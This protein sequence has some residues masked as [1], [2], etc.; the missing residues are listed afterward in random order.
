V[1][2]WQDGLF[3]YLYNSYRCDKFGL[4]DDE[5]YASITKFCTKDALKRHIMLLILRAYAYKLE[6]SDMCAK[7]YNYF[8][9]QIY[10]IIYHSC[11]IHNIK[12]Y[13]RG[14]KK[15]KPQLVEKRKSDPC[16]FDPYEQLSPKPCEDPLK[17][18]IHEKVREVI[19]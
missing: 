7:E 18:S 2:F 17:L 9:V 11:K 1:A 13:L 16:L 5:G 12:L 8:S 15:P 14:A 4:W 6:E 10:Q 3:W 19:F